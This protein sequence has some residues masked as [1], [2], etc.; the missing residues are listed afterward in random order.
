MMMLS[1][2]VF[3]SLI[4]LDTNVIRLVFLVSIYDP[5]DVGAEVGCGGGL[6]GGPAYRGGGRRLR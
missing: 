3:S 6:G 4:E 1:F 2:L 5:D